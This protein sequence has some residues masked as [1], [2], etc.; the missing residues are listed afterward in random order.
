MKKKTI[1]P[2]PYQQGAVRM[3]YMAL[4]KFRKALV[5]MATGLGKTITAAMIAKKLN[6]GPILFLVHNNFILEHAIEEFKLV[7]GDTVTMATYNGLT[8]EGAEDA[9]IV[10][11]TWQTMGMNLKSWGRRYFKLIIVDEAHHTEAETYVPCITYFQGMKLGITATPDRMD[12]TDIRRI[13]GEEVVNIP[14]EEAVARG[15]L[16]EVEYHLM[17]DESMDE[18]ALQE[19]TAEIR[20]SKRRFTIAEVNRRVFIR[21][22]DKD[23]SNIIAR[24]PEK[25]AVFCSS[26]PHAVNMAEFLP[27]AKAFHSGKDKIHKTAQRVQ[28]R[29]RQTLVDLKE[30]SI[31][32]VTTV[33][34]FN[35]GVDVPDIELIVFCRVT[36]SIR[37]WRQQLGRGMRPGKRKVIVY[38]FV[39]NLE[40]VQLVLE[41]VNRIADL[42]EKFTNKE[43]RER[44]GWTRERFMVSGAGFK[45]TF[46]DQIV[47]LMA[48]LEHCERQIY[49]TWQEAGAA[50]VKL[51]I[52]T[53]TE[54]KAHYKEDQKLPSEPNKSYPNFPNWRVFLG[55]HEKS[56]YRTWQQASKA[57]IALG[58]KKQVEYRKRYVEDPRL[59]SSP[60][61]CYPS[62]PRWRVFLGGKPKNF[63][64]T[65]QQASKAAQAKGINSAKKYPCD[66]KLDLRL[67]AAPYEYYLD[68]PGWSVFLGKNKD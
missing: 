14:F 49:P 9:Q 46:S 27:D 2:R 20:Q 8:K 28:D 53:Y 45:F 68:W 43:E 5:V 13:F 52:T 19:I 35:E 36:G 37:I 56:F 7:F 39:G 48:V 17:M 6:V 18:N 30:G 67:P 12:N 62:F 4:K 65:W 50:A 61:V 16:P 55:R 42:H 10:F 32:R 24:R 31:T 54:Y 33:N 21:K 25:A 60:D 23:I 44:E 34:A 40:R 63:Y 11:A 1:T 51:G 29:N 38:D 59:P 64:E 26:I 3:A 58:I 47:D 66:Y 15:W 41:S 22:R 57:A